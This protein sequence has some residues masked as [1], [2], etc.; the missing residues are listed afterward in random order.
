MKKPV[1]GI[2]MGDPAGIG[3]EILIKA[4]QKEE[5]R[6]ICQPII[7][8]NPHMLKTESIDNSLNLVEI[9]TIDQAHFSENR[10]NILDP[11]KKNFGLEVK[12]K[13]SADSGRAAFQYIKTSIEL[14]MSKKIDSV[15]TGPI[16]KEAIKAANLEFIGHTEMFAQLT[17]SQDPLTVFEVHN[18][19]IFFLS[20]H[21]SLRESCDL[22][23]KE[24][25]LD[26]IQ[27]SMEALKS[28]GLGTGTFAVA[29]LNPHASDN[30]LFGHEEKEAIIPAIEEAKSRGMDV[31]GP[32]GADSVFHMAMKNDWDGVLS[33]YHDQG[34]I[35]A[36][37]FDFDRTI[38]LTLGL[39]FLRTS[40][41][42]G[43]AFDI[44][45]KGLAQSISMEEAIK[46]AVKYSKK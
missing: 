5:I 25:V 46:K 29:G 7:L 28:L 22:V 31:I 10:V 3:P 11:A 4:L 38:S 35:A 41:D 44:A 39:P 19:R 36:K 13:I 43:T 26:Y 32:I 34:H 18:L 9:I 20:R 42:H 23:T 37:T 30:G 2:T 27:R 17:D 8:G 16:H 1:I 15:V 24:R 12:G 45:G 6:R 14:A 33:L 40:V 21:V